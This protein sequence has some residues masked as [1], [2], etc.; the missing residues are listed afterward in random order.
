MS[1]VMDS[2]KG[3]KSLKVLPST[4]ISDEEKKA[5]MNTIN[6]DVTNWI[7]K[8]KNAGADNYELSAALEVLMKGFQLSNGQK[9]QRMRIKFTNQREKAGKP[10]IWTGKRFENARAASR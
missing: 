1:K 4:V 3:A 10:V 5:I 9:S 8:M 6:A 2:I 7:S